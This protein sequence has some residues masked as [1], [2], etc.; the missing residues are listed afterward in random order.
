MH[1]LATRPGAIVDGEEAVDL[2]QSPGDIV[3]LSAADTEIACLA[4]AQSRLP[5]EAPTLRLANLLRLG[6]PLS[7]DLHVDRVV[8]KARLVVVRL[9]GGRAYWRYGIERV[10]ETCRARGI[11]LVVLPGDDRE[12]PSL[13]GLSSVAP[14]E[15]ARLW[16]HLSAG[17]VDNAGGFLAAAAAL[18]GQGAEPPPPTPVPA[19]GIHR[20]APADG[21]P[22]A[23]VTFY[24]ALVL[25][26][27]TETIDALCD[28]LEAEGLA[29]TALWV[30]SLKDEAARAAI[31]AAPGGPPAIVLNLTGFAVGS[32]EGERRAT[33][34]DRFDCPV[35]QLVLS[36][37]TEAAWRDGTRGLSPKDLA[38]NVAL[39]EIDG[40]ILTRAVAFKAETRWD[41][42]TECTI[43]GYRPLT[44]RLEF[45]AALAAGWVRLRMT[46][47][48][49]RRVALILANYPSRDGRLANGVGLDTPASAVAI[50][51]A[52]AAEGYPVSGAPEDAAA[53]MALLQAAPTNAPGSADRPG[54]E[55]LPLAE[56]EAA[57]ASLPEAV[58]AQVV[59]RWG[60]PAADPAVRD[61]A[62]RLALHRLGGTVIGIQPT[63]GYELD[64]KETY[65]AP[66]LPPPHAYLA[67]YAWLRRVFGA[68]AVVHVGKHG[69]LEWLP[70][71]A[72]ALSS[73]CL[74]DAILGPVPQLYPFIVN[75][76]G[77][78][79]QAKRRTAAVVIDH[80][81]PPLAR[82]G[83]HAGLAELE[84]LV[85]E[86]YEA[87]ALDPR[88]LAPL[89]ERILEIAAASGLDHDLG[90]AGLAPDEALARIDGHLCELKEMQIRDGLHVFGTSPAGALR[91]ELLLALLR[92]A[93]GDGQGGNAGILQALAADLGLDPDP[94]ARPLA[95]PWAGPRPAVLG[96][97]RGWRSTGDTIERLEALALRLVSGEA[98]CDPAW[99]RTASVLRSARERIGPALDA[100]GRAEM[101]AL[102]AG[103]AGR[104]VAPGP[105]GAP[106]RGRPEVLPTGRNFFSV[107]S[108]AVPTPAAWRLGWHSASLLVERHA[109]EEGDWPRAMALSVWGT[110]NM[111]TGGDDVAQALALMGVQPRWD[112]ATGRVIG[113]EIL[114][115]SVLG[116]PRVDV[117]IR[118]SGF[119]RD[120]FPSQMDLLD[121]A[122][123]A[124][125][126]LDEPEED[127]P[128]AARV[129][130]ET[131]ALVG[132]GME[133]MAAARIA[134]HRVF[135]S[136]PGAYGAG[137]QALIDSGA[138]DRRADLAEAFLE[139]GGHAYG[140]GAQGVTARDALARRLAQVDAVIHNQDNREHDLL[141]SDDYYQFEGG[142]A[143]TV[144]H[145]SGRA[146]A[147][148]HN[149][150]S[151]PDRP[152]VRSLSE[153]IARVVRGRAT[154]P[155]WIAGV[156]RH[157]YKGAFEM[158]ATVD[159]LFAFAATT[160]A[161][162]SHHFD[163]VFEAYLQDEAVRGFLLYA[164]PA[165]AREIAERFVEA[166]RRGL[167]TPRRNAAGP[168]AEALA[169]GRRDIA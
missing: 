67:F 13:E 15:R 86:A 166:Q 74:P 109:Q 100:C 40:R 147:V 28:T 95:E 63:R 76:P 142:L 26:G 111:R 135:G 151:R 96:P 125:A 103:L 11:P 143:A 59:G 165:A 159:Y 27:G 14:A 130:A 47:P 68:Q 9:L 77:E 118:V 114:P 134:G 102:L 18:I 101:A 158:A 150:H 88:R 7:V 43:A 92:T 169:A 138:W 107:D 148:W 144:E 164:N 57:F 154:H 71:K 112:E 79:S 119:F 87:A 23:L 36:G 82:A 129:R 97:E 78:G 155:R 137:L 61:G 2:A 34:F 42:R 50:L 6:H 156:M 3:V 1:L 157:G 167:W 131:A 141:D 106:T 53:L 38:M 21:R 60:P 128:L 120:A 64:P 5:P 72:L 104:F 10:A 83:S 31:A 45:A 90:L 22:R 91:S 161:V 146:P 116:R 35:L 145:L 168:L 58:Q 8:A 55:T 33:P 126:A 75:D 121:S 162:K 98:A 93:R 37:E 160:E 17:G 105:S 32:P 73:D 108:R 16:S 69:N 54:G 65:H 94:A 46:P 140:G 39:T 4:A 99:R 152:V 124:V 133:P 136:K 19:C 81:T 85:D 62:F 163:A 66:D 49:G 48:D 132:A 127:N 84:A 153:E 56:Y 25:A 80:L 29:P 52:M 115:A 24:R 30:P 110:S 113:F 117:T 44:D 89:R 51:Q 139:W 122:A 20:A 70:G 123:R 41:A 12:D 149:D